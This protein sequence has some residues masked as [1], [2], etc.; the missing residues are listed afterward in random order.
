MTE[1]L[2]L[3]VKREHPD[4]VVAKIVGHEM[5]HGT[6]YMMCR[7]KG[8]ITEMDTT[9]EAKKLFKSCPTR[10]TEYNA[11]DRTEKD[12]ALKNDFIQECFPSLEHGTEIEKRRK[13]PGEVAKGKRKRQRVQG[14]TI[15]QVTE[16]A[17]RKRETE[18]VKE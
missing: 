14:R 2:Q 3:E 15:T 5:K 16:E 7:W 9:Q 12:K 4:N 6:L 13:K 8:F 10:I 17:R 18:K 11:A 1:Q